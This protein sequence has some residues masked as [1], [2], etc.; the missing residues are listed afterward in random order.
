MLA[1]SFAQAKCTA[2]LQLDTAHIQIYPHC[3]VA[4]SVCN[5]CGEEDLLP[6]ASSPDTR[7]THR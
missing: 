6:F 2:D 3:T 4:L 1:V 7:Y 5:L